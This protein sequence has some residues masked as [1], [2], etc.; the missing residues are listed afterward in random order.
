MSLLR[1]LRVV[2]KSAN[3]QNLRFMGNSPPASSFLEQS[4]VAQ[5]VANV[6]R[7][8][9]QCPPSISP[10]D[11]LTADLKFDSLSRKELNGKLFE[12]FRVSPDSKAAR[13]FVTVD[14]CTQYFAMHPK[15]R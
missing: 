5:R 14:A 9:R 7:G 12:E 10:G 2:S 4:E 13:S 15:A 11:N 3:F 8:F 6:I 1:S